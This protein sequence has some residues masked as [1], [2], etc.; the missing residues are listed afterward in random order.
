MSWKEVVWLVTP[1]AEPVTV[2]VTVP[3]A[4]LALAESVSVL[5]V[6][7][8]G[9]GVGLNEPVT[10]AGN[11]DAVR[12][13]ASVNEPVREIDRL[14]VWVAPRATETPALVPVS[15]KP[16]AGGG[17][18]LVVPPLPPPPPHPRPKA[19]ATNATTVRVKGLETNVLGRARM[20]LSGG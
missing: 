19:I 17:G 16:P 15:V 9:I 1:F 13:T 10:P 7:P 5:V 12:L 2:T 6:C 18:G 11:P 4:A 3:V 20:R 14:T 8:E